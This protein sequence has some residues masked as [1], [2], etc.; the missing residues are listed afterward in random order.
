MLPTFTNIP[1]VYVRTYTF[2]RLYIYHPLGLVNGRISRDGSSWWIHRP[3]QLSWVSPG[4]QCPGSIHQVPQSQSSSR[5]LRCRAEPIEETHVW[6]AAFVKS[7]FVFVLLVN[8]KNSWGELKKKIN[9]FSSWRKK[10]W[11][12]WSLRPTSFESV[13]KALSFWAK[14]VWY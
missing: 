5:H 3:D 11:W 9:W 12:G 2:T 7:I 8:S 13:F 14:S 4:A 6:V 1:E 10:H